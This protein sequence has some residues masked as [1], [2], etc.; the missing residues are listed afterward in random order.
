MDTWITDEP[1]EFNRRTTSLRFRFHV[2][3]AGVLAV[4]G[5]LS[6]W[7]EA[8]LDEAAEH[9][10]LY[11]RLRP[12]VQ[13][14]VQYRLGDPAVSPLTGV[15]YVHGDRIAVLAFKTPWHSNRALAPLRPEGIAADSRWVDEDTGEIHWGATLNVTGLPLRW[16]GADWDSAI[17][18][19]RRVK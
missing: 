13:H 10:A 14:G 9:V 11:K 6:E 3:S 8:E 7:S 2:A 17:L 4:G 1:S 18:R 15:Q 16:S 19:L 5:N 12:V